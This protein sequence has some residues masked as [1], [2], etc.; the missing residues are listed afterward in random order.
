MSPFIDAIIWRMVNNGLP[1]TC[2]YLRP[3]GVRGDGDG[4]AT[5]A[6]DDAGIEV[7]LSRWAAKPD[8]PAI[9]SDRL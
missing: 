4:M 6:E 5:E 2:H 8:L 9:V 7:E 1:G 3:Q